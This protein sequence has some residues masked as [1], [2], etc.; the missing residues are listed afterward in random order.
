MSACKTGCGV[1]VKDG[2]TFCVTC[3]EEWSQSYEA[4]R[5]EV[6]VMPAARNVALVDFCDR[7]RAER[8]NKPKTIP[9]G[10]TCQTAGEP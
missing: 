7:V 8:A 6:A 10:P 2:I 5:A 4:R 1:V 3:F 9:E